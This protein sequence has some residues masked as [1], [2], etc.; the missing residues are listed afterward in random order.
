[1][2][3]FTKAQLREF[4]EARGAVEWREDASNADGAYLRNRMRHELVP[5]LQ[6]LTHGSLEARLDA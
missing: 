6:E 4:V 1:M 2:L 5:L 3:D